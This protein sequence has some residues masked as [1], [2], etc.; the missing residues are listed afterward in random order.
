MEAFVV[1]KKKQQEQH[2]ALELGISIKQE[3]TEQQL[4]FY[5]QRVELL[6]KVLNQLKEGKA[7]GTFHN[8]HF[9]IV[10]RKMK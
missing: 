2:Q 3:A 1:E 6:E 10:N 9:V 8:T 5:Q 4:A 7:L